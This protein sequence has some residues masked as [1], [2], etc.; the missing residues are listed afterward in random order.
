L[1]KRDGH[2]RE[3]MESFAHPTTI[4]KAMEAIC[5]VCIITKF[6]LLEKMKPID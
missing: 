2:H 4:D 1:T 3:E 5:K 6:Q